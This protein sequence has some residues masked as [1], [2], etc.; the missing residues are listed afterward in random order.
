MHDKCAIENEWTAAQEETRNALLDAAERLLGQFGYRRLSVEDIA[1]EA[2][3]SR[4]TFY[5]YFSSKEEITLATGDRRIARL[6]AL[7]EKDAATALPAADRLRR[8]LIGRVLFMF[9]DVRNRTA[10][11]D[12]II[13][14]T[15]TAYMP[16]RIGYLRAEAEVFAKVLRQAQLSGELSVDDADRM[17]MTLLLATNALM[18]FSLSAEQ[19]MD[20][21]WVEGEISRI[22]DV[23][24]HGL[25]TAPA[26]Q[27][28]T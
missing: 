5:L 12:E 1:T 18:P 15:R 19:R 28:N 6:V 3:L 13:E 2:G 22:A 25:K 8:M 11:F 27:I 21:D 7:L 4:R 10:T 16:R 17:A 20:R 14:S 26:T 23:L 24:M 9:D